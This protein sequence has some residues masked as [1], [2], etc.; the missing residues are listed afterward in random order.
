MMVELDFIINSPSLYSHAWV[1]FVG[2]VI[3]PWEAFELMVS[4]VFGSCNRKELLIQAPSKTP[5]ALL[6][7]L[8]H[9]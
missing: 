1:D 9:I 5:R 2:K 4:L 7:G 3:T 6:C 8:R